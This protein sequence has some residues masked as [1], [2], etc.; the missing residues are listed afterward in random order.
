[1]ALWSLLNYGSIEAAAT[2]ILTSLE[3]PRLWR[4]FSFSD[5]PSDTPNLPLLP[6]RSIQHLKGQFLVLFRPMAMY[7]VL[8]PVELDTT[9]KVNFHG[10][11]LD[12]QRWVSRVGVLRS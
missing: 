10:L 11:H 1:M 3:L 2:K 12:L 9:Y 8:S 6:S 7:L 5:T 4:T